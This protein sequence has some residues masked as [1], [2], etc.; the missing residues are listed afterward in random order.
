[1]FLICNVGMLG[2]LGRTQKAMRCSRMHFEQLL[3]F[4]R[5]LQTL[6][7]Y[8]YID[9]RTLSM[10]QFILF[11]W[12]ISFRI[13]IDAVT[14]L[15]EY[16]PWF[17]GCWTLVLKKMYRPFLLLWKSLSSL[18]LD[19]KPSCFPRHSMKVCLYVQHIAQSPWLYKVPVISKTIGLLKNCSPANPVSGV[20][21]SRGIYL[22]STDY[23]SVDS[24]SI[25]PESW[26]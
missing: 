3:R 4:C 8:P 7:V 24:N 16:L 18:V 1:M 13:S 14:S 5:A 15:F 6:R 17:T 25:N 23:W 9:T 2:S 20:H 12:L 26:R 22:E 19:A 21:H 11:V 10:S